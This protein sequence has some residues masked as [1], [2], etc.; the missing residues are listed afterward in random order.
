MPSLR[1]DVHASGS[2]DL[3]VSPCWGEGRRVN[4]D[5]AEFLERFN[6]LLESH[7]HLDIATGW[8][9]CGRQAQTECGASR[10]PRHCS[11]AQDVQCADALESVHLTIHDNH[12]VL[13]GSL[14]SSGMDRM[15]WP[16]R[17]DPPSTA[18]SRPWS[19]QDLQKAVAVRTALC[20]PRWARSRL[21]SKDPAAFRFASQAV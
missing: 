3:E 16:R 20:H 19:R 18:S 9:T 10:R 4:F 13:N 2:G 14:T 7:S 8:A 1:F 6:V 21:D 5:G 11:D 15:L 12:R 17:N